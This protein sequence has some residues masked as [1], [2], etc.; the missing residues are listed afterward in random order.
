[1]RRRALRLTLCLPLALL[2]AACPGSKSTQSLASASAAP[3]A[4]PV[5]IQTGEL[6]SPS[7]FELVALPDGLRLLW[8]SATAGAGWLYE[9]E[10]AH[11]GTPRGKPRRIALPARTLGKITDLNA[12][13]V[14]QQMALA[15][16]DQGKNEARASASLIAGIEPPLVLDL[17]AAAS[18][19]ESARG[20]IALVAE[21]DQKGA[22]V[23][24]RGLPAPCV[25]PESGPCVGF[26]FR[27]LRAGAAETMGLPL[28]VPVPCASHSVQ[29]GASAG[30]FHYGVCTREGAEPVTTMFTIQSEPSYARA[31][32][33][34]K[35]CVPLG[36][37]DVAGS[38]WLIA[39]CHGKRK[40]V[41]VPLADEKVQAEYI[42]A[43]R[44]SCTPQRAELRQGRFVLELR[45]PRGD[46]QAVLPPSLLP[47]GARAGWTGKS[48]VV[49]YPSG[50][51]LETRVLSCRDGRL[52][53]R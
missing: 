38:P 19:A 25:E 41:P 42:D 28:S 36:T 10:L 37:L 29:L 15:W 6:S 30:R 20:N 31:E 17:G 35:G 12:S 21:R 7:A 13:Y 52:E 5:V 49:V 14:G 9:A 24:W 16:L 46:L 44:M 2:C 32:P 34:L 11:D 26:A 45:E 47:T 50:G 23:M 48:L 1:M 4:A 22:L 51:Q 8:A 18:S 27:R 40:A 33:L 43:P 39:D 3:P 53:P